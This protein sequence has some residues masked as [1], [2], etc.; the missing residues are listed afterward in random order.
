MT[1]TVIFP[2]EAR[3]SAHSNGCGGLFFI[4]ALNDHGLDCPMSRRP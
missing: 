1:L 2:L 4:E 3:E